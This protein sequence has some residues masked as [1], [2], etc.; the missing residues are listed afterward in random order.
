MSTETTMIRHNTNNSR[1]Q[2]S[3]FSPQ[4][5]LKRPIILSSVAD[6]STAPLLVEDGSESC[7][8][9]QDKALPQEQQS[10]DEI[11]EIGTRSSYSSNLKTSKKN[12]PRRNRTARV[13]FGEVC[14]RKY[15]RSIGDWWDIQHG[16]GL[17]WEY[18][19]MP[20][21]RL[22]SLQEDKSKAKKPAKSGKSKFMRMLTLGNKQGEPKEIDAGVSVDE[23]ARRGKGK[24]NS[25][26]KKV[27]KTKGG[28]TKTTRRRS[29]YEDCKPTAKY[30]EQLLTEFGFSET[31]L[32][33]SEKE[34]KLLRLEYLNW[35]PKSK[36][37]SDLFAER[38]LASSEDVKQ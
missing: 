28:R 38:C 16:L 12:K 19:E 7:S 37:S 14:V 36:R 27:G 21:E 15:D 20:A 11:D 26:E 4:L 33:E 10:G 13:C 8:K 9:R 25:N 5:S 24:R 35:T 6:S 31:E 3:D 18:A 17:A 2:Q 34:R 29:S 1:R 30:R 32:E 22:P 23:T